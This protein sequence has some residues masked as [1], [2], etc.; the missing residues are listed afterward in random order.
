EDIKLYFDRAKIIQ[1]IIKKNYP[2]V[3]KKMDNVMPVGKGLDHLEP[4][5]KNNIYDTTLPSCVFLNEDGQCGVYDVRPSVCRMYGSCVLCE[6]I[7]NEQIM[8]EKLAIIATTEETIIEKRDTIV[9]KRP[10]PIFYWL[11][12]MNES[13]QHYSF[14]MDKLNRFRLNSV[15]TYGDYTI[16]NNNL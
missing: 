11:C 15:R 6:K 7:N 8:D 3:Y 5:L 16:K 13:K 10:Y 4:Y 1:D 14:F 12:L 9:V 2:D